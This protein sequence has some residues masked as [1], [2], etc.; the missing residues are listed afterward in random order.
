MKH[1]EG[2]TKW[3]KEEVTHFPWSCHIYGNVSLMKMCKLSWWCSYRD[4]GT[5]MWNKLFQIN[6]KR[7]FL[8]YIPQHILYQSL[9]GTFWRLLQN[10]QKK[11]GKI[12]NNAEHNFEVNCQTCELILKGV[13]VI[14]CDIRHQTSGDQKQHTFL[15][16]VSVHVTLWSQNDHL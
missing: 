15:Y 13:Q 11:T 12:L 1:S 4:F 5:W 10:K 9:T 16:W 3:R 8:Q 6:F 7:M 2:I 14:R